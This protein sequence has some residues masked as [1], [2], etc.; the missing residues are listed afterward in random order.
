M[1][2]HGFSSKRGLWLTSKH[3]KDGQNLVA[4]LTLSVKHY[5]KNQE[6]SYLPELDDTKNA[7]EKSL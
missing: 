7:V 4:H 5:H 6:M 3:S 1:P 2:F